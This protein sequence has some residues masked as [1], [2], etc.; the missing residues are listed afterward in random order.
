MPWCKE[1]D[2]MVQGR[3][4]EGGA[5]TEEGPCHQVVQKAKRHPAPIAAISSDLGLLYWILRI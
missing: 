3:N 1:D 2:H 4:F 5:V